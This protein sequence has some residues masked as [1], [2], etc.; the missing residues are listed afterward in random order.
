MRS[1]EIWPFIDKDDDY[2]STWVFNEGTIS[3]HSS[4]SAE[5]AIGLRS[6]HEFERGGKGLEE[7]KKLHRC[8]KSRFSRT[9]MIE[10]HIPGLYKLAFGLHK[11]E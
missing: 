5:K 3:L 1:V 11:E 6:L 4:M 7:F 9:T 10:N 8:L 2:T